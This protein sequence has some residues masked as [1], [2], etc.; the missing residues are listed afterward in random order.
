MVEEAACVSQE[1]PRK[2]DLGAEPTAGSGQGLAPQCCH[3][4]SRPG[5]L[6]LGLD[7]LDSEQPW[8]HSMPGTW[9][10]WE[11]TGGYEGQ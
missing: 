1:L 10:Q 11:E 2:A 4:Q 9:D 7:S 8:D 5:L 3:L 6:V